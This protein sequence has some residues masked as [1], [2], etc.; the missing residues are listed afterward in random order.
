MEL[1]GSKTEEVLMKAFSAEVGVSARYRYFAGAAREAGLEQIADLFEA[2]AMNEAEHARHEFEFLGGSGDVVENLEEAIKGEHAEATRFYKEAAET[3]AGEGF[4]EVADF[5]NRMRKVEAKHEKNFRDILAGLEKGGE[6][7]GRTVGHSA[8]EMA[9]V[10]LP[11]QANPA[12]FVHGGELMKLMDNAAGVVAA[13]HCRTNI[14]TG[15]VEDIVFHSPVR[16]GS[17]VIVHG[18]LT[19]TSRSSMEVQVRVEME[20]LLAGERVEA[21]TAYFVMVALDAEGRPAT[22]PTLILSTEEEERLFGE[23]K[24]RYEARKAAAAQ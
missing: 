1:K 6:F 23:G 10:M 16:V 12:G 14:V 3:A 2:T 5:F 19:F 18:K 17:L 15:R 20:N 21:L 22:V 8:V 11:D 7:E 9:Q 24:T 13:R 4:T